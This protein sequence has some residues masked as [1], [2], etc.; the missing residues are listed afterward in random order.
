[1]TSFEARMAVLGERFRGRAR[2]DAARIRGALARGELDEVMRA[3]HGL[4]GVAGIFGHHA[5]GDAAE[6]VELGVDEALPPAEV[7]SRCRQLLALLD[8]VAD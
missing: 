7:E 4:A 1:V 6:R 8:E 5:I 2:D 3:S